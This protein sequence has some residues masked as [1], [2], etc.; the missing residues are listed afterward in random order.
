MFKIAPMLASGSTGVHKSPDLTP[1]TSLRLVELWHEI[2]GVPP[3]VLNAVPG[4]GAIAGE[5]LT[6]HSDV[7]KIAFTGSTRIG[8]HIMGRCAQ[9][10][11]KLTLELGGK[12]P[13]VVFGDGDVQKAAFYASMFGLANSGQFCAAPT[14]LIVEESVYDEFV[15]NML[16]HVGNMKTGYWKEEGVNKGPVVSQAQ[17]DSIMNYIKIGKESGA[18]LLCGGNGIDRDGF[19]IEPTIFGNVGQD[20]KL[21]QDEIF[22]PVL[23]I[24]K[25]KSGETAAQDAL[26]IANNSQYGLM[27]GVF[28]KDAAKQALFSQ[29]LECGTVCTNNYA[30][31]FYDS[32][33]GGLKQSGIGQEL[34]HKG[35]ESY[36]KSKTVIMDQN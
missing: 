2:E 25:F 29:K 17:K 22:G 21:A 13:L 36:L 16:H 1:L 31:I 3:G 6:T 14:R 27:G 9:D 11:K 5:A 30:S 18:D 28:T 15:A 23:S 8:K 32:E 19:F 7:N 35:L 33:F 34:G 24:I 20:D 10:L 4:D 12:G 26:N